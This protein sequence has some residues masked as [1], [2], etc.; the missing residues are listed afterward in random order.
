ML[1]SANERSRHHRTPLPYRLLRLDFL[2]YLLYTIYASI[3]LLFHLARFTPADQHYA[4]PSLF[5]GAMIKLLVCIWRVS[6]PLRYIL[7]PPTVP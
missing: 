4:L 2:Y 6:V 1:S 3:P 7:S 5:P